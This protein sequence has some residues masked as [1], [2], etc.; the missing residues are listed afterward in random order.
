[1]SHNPFEIFLTSRVSIHKRD[2]TRFEK[3]KASVADGKIE[4]HDATLL[5]EEGDIAV[6]HLPNGRDE[7]YQVQ[8]VIFKEGIAGPVPD[9]LEVYCRRISMPVFVSHHDVILVR[10][11]GTPHETRWETQM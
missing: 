5:I 7:P 10:D 9:W 4:I 3:L 2:G 6:H 11:A 1:M 8:R